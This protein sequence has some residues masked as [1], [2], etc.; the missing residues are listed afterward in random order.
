M[1][2]FGLFSSINFTSYIYPLENGENT[3]YMVGEKK[4]GPKK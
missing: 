3:F 1:H 2:L 4:L